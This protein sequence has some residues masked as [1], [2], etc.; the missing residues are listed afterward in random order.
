MIFTFLWLVWGHFVCDFPLQGDFLA[1]GKNH[2]SPIAGI[3]WWWCLLAHCAIH[4][5][6]VYMVTGSVALCLAELC[7][8]AVIDYNKNSGRYEFGTDQML[9]LLCKIAWMVL[10]R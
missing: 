10:A 9:H 6:W 8:H 4:A 2:V 3:P 5:G 7:A 1:R